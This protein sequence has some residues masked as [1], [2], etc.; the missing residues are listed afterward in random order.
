MDA[1]DLIS[2]K[3]IYTDQDLTIKAPDGFYREGTNYRQMINGELLQALPCPSCDLPSEPCGAGLAYSGGQS[4]PTSFNIVLGDGQGISGLTYDA[5]NVP[6]RFIVEW[7]GNIVIDTG[8][9]GAISYDFGNDNRSNFTASLTGKTDPVTNTVYPDLVNFPDDGYPR[10][11][12]PGSGTASFAKNKTSPFGSILSIYGPQAGTAW[13]ASLGCPANPDPEPPVGTYLF[14]L[15]TGE[16]NQDA[17]CLGN[18]VASTPVYTADGDGTLAS[19]LNA[20]LYT[21][22]ALTTLFDGGGLYYFASTFS[23]DSSALYPQVRVIQ[24]NISGFVLQ[25]T[26]YVCP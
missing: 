4:Y 26:N 15:S 17:F 7:D 18:F 24:V 2:T 13:N 5:F 16:I 20:D 23:G 1:P 3:S 6:D 9:V 12:S 10:V 8:Y 22:P 21:D 25:N 11:T 19:L 14:Y